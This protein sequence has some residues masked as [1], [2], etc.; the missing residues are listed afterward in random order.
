MKNFI[1][2]AIFS[3]FTF[4][5]FGQFYDDCATAGSNIDNI[6]AGAI[7]YSISG[8]I[9]I[10]FTDDGSYDAT[11]SFAAGTYTTGFY[12]FTVPSNGYYNI[13]FE[14]SGGGTAATGD[15]SVG[16]D[17]TSGT[18]PGAQTDVGDIATG[19]DITS[20]CV[21]LTAGTTYYISMALENGHEGDFTI[22]IDKGE[23]VCEGALQEIFQGDNVLD[24]SCSSNPPSPGTSGTI[25]TTYTVVAGPGGE[26]DHLTVDI[27][28][29]VTGSLNPAFIYQ[30]LLNDCTGD[31]VTANAT[32]LN[33]GDVLYIESGNSS[34]AYGDYTVHIDQGV[35]DVA[36]DDCVD[37]EDR[38]TLTCSATVTGAADANA[39]G[40]EQDCTPN[41]VDGVWYHFVASSAVNTFDFTGSEFRVW[42][43]P[44]CANLTDLGCA[45][46]AALTDVLADPTTIYWVMVYGSGSFTATSDASVPANDL[47]ADAVALVS[48]TTVE[49]STFCA[50]HTWA[51]CALDASSHE[52]YY[53]YTNNTGN[54][55]DIDV[56]VEGSTAT[57]G[58]TA[59]AAVD[60]AI[61]TDACT[62]AAFN[63]QGPECNTL[64][65]SFN[66]ACI[67]P[68][69][70]LILAVGS[71]EGSEGDFKITITE[72]TAGH[73]A[74]DVCAGAG[75]FGEIASSCTKVD[76]PADN[77]GA[78]SDNF[79]DGGCAFTPNTMKSVWY[80][81]STDANAKFVDIETDLTD[82][83]F[84]LYTGP[85]CDNLTYEASSCTS[86]GTLDNLPVLPNTT[87]YILIGSNTTEG[88][89]N[90]GITVKNIPDNNLCAD[91]IDLADGL[92]GTNACADA[93]YDYCAQVTG[94]THEVYY[95]YTNNN[96]ANVDLDVTVTG[97]TNTTGTA[98]T[99][100]DVAI[101]TDACDG[102]LYNAPN[103]TFCATL[104]TQFTIECIEDGETIILVF[105]SEDTQ[106][107][108]FG[109]S[110]TE[111]VS[112]VTNDECSGADEITY[113]ACQWESVS[114]DNTNACFEDFTAAG[115]DYDTEP[116]VWMKFIATAD[117][118]SVE[119]D[120]FTT[121]GTG[122]LGLFEETLDC[123]NQT[124]AA[125]GSACNTGAGPFGPF[126]ITG[127]NT[128]YIAVGSSGG[129]GAIDFDIKVNESPVNDDPCDANFAPKDIADGATL[130]E[131]NTCAGPD[132]TS[133]N[134]DNTS[135]KTL[136]YEHT[137]TQDADLE[138]TV[139]GTTATGPFTI[140]T[141]DGD[142]ACGDES[143]FILDN[144]TDNTLTLLCKLQGEKVV[145][146]I[147]TSET[148]G[149][150][151]EYE[152]SVTE[153]VVARPAND[154]CTDAEEIIYDDIDLCK[155]KGADNNESNI[156]ACSEDNDFGTTCD[157]TNEEV[158]WFEFTTPPATVAG[159]SVSVRFSNYTGTGTLFA[160]MFDDGNDCTALTVA[161][162]G[163]CATGNGPNGLGTVDPNTTYLIGVGSTGDTGGDFDIEIKIT[164]GPPNDDACADMT[165]FDLTG[166]GTL[167]DEQT[168]ACSG[169]GVSF[170]D[171]SG[172]DQTNAVFYTFTI[173]APVY[174]INVQITQ[175]GSEPIQGTVVAGISA[176]NT[177][178]CTGTTYTAP[179]HCEDISTAEFEWKCLDEGT[180][181]LQISTSEDNSGTFEITS[182]MLEKPDNGCNAND[183][184]E[185]AEELTVDAQCEWVD[186][187]KECN[188][189]AC[190]DPYTVGACDLSQ[191]PTVWYKVLIPAGAA[192]I[193]VIVDNPTSGNV[194]MVVAKE[195]DACPL[196]AGWCGSGGT[197]AAP[198]ALDATDEGTYFYIAVTDPTGGN[199][200]GYD[201][202]IKIDV[203]PINDSPCMANDRPP[204]DLG[205]G[206][207]H[208][209]TTCCAVG[210]NDD[211][212]QDQANVSCNSA[213][214]DNAVWYRVA[215]D[216]ASDGV[217]INITGGTIGGSIG[218]EVYVGG[219]DAACD[220]T[221]EF[222]KSK[223]DGL[224]VTDMHIGCLE[225]GDYV[226]IKVASSDNDGDCGTFDITVE[227]IKDCDIADACEDITGAQE[228]DPV[229][230][231]DV[232]VNYVCTQGC[233]DLACPDPGLPGGCAGFNTQPTVWFQINTDAD[234]A[235]LYTSVE[236]SGS[237]TPVWSIF[238]SPNDD[239]T[240][241]QNA[242]GTGS[243]PCSL[244]AAP[245]APPLIT[246]VTEGV[247]YIAVSANDG[248]VIDDPNF[249][250]C[251]ATIKNVVVCLGPDVGCGNDETLVFEVTERENTDAE[252]NGPPYEGPFCPG[253][254]VTVHMQFTYDAT[255]TGDDWI[256]GLIPKFGD[257]WDMTGFDFAGNPPSGTPMGAADYYDENG[258]CPPL[259]ME[260]FSF[261]CTYTDDQGHLRLCNTLCENCPCTGGMIEQDPL[262]SGYFW[263][264]EGTSPDCDANN[265][266]PSRKYGI[267]NPISNIEW[268]IN[269][270][271]KEFATQD[272]CMA[273]DDLLI[274]FMTFSDGGAGC[275]D[276]PIGEC[277]ID[278]PQFSPAWKVNCDIPP[279]V[280]ATPQPQDI[281]SG[282]EAGIDVT[283]EDGSTELIEITYDDNP[284]VDG[285]NDHSFSD[286][287]GTIDDVLTINDP[288]LCDVEVVTYYA[289]VIIPGM[290]CEGKTDTI[291]VNVYPLPRI[292]E[293]DEIFGAC[294]SDLPYDLPIDAECG[295]P[296]TYTFSWMDDLSSKSGEGDNI[297]IDESFGAGLHT[298]SITVT[299]ELGCENTGELKFNVYPDV[300]FKLQGD[301]LCWGEYKEF[302]VDLLGRES[303]DFEF[304]WY[305]DPG[306]GYSGGDETYIIETDEYG[307][308]YSPSENPDDFQL[309][310]ELKE[311][312][313][314]GVVCTHDTCVNVW[315]RK[316]MNLSLN[317][318]NPVYICEGQNCV[319]VEVVFD[320]DN[321]MLFDEVYEIYW[322]GNIT[323]NPEYEFCET[324][325]GNFVQI[326]DVFGC[327]TT[328]DFDILPNAVTDIEIVGDTSICIGDCTTLTV[329]G[330]FDSYAWNTG[331]PA[332]TTKS[333][334]VC[335]MDDLT[336]YEVSAIN[337]SGCVSNGSINVH[338]FTAEVPNIPPTATFC[339]G[340]STTISAPGGYSSYKWY[341]NS[342]GGTPVSTTQDVVID[343]SGNYIIV[344]VSPEGCTAQDTVV[345]SEASE[346]TPYVVGDTSLC[347]EDDK[348]L[349]IALGG[350]FTVYEW[351]FNDASG[352][353]VIPE[354]D[355][356]SIYLAEGTYYLYVSDGNCSG[357]TTF[358]ITRRPKIEPKIMP[359]VD[360]IYICYD[361]DTT[362][363]AP[364]GFVSYK[365]S[366]GPFDRIVSG[367]GEGNYYVTVTD[368]EG[369]QGVDSIYVD[370]YP[371]MYPSLQDSVQ[372]CADDKAILTPG[373]FA[374][375]I[376]SKDNVHLASFD[377]EESIEVTEGG[378]YSVI[379]SNAIGCTA[380]DTIK[381][382]K[383][384]NLTP[385]IVGAKDLC[386][387]DEITLSVSGTY[388]NYKWTNS[389]GK[390]L[391]TDATLKFTMTL[392]K[393][394]ETVLLEVKSNSGCLGSDQ[395]TINRY[396]TPELELDHMRIEVCG[397]GSTNPGVLN[398]NDYFI[399]GNA[400]IGNW[401]DFDNS[402]ATHNA[403][404]SNV[405]FTN[406]VVDTTY[407]FVFRTTTAKAP[408]EDV[409]DTIYVHVKECSCEQWKL[410]PFADVCNDEN[411]AQINL[412]EHV[413]NANGDRIVPV[414]A[415]VWTV[416]PAG[417]GVLSGNKFIAA[418]AESGTYT[419]TYKFNDKGV[420]CTDTASQ[421]ITVQNAVNPGTPQPQHVC[422]GAN[423]VFDLGGLLIG[424]DAGGTWTEVSSN[425]STGGAF[426]A[427]AGTFTTNG[428]NIGEY[429]FEYS[430]KGVDPCPDK[431]V[432]VSVIIDPTP[433]ADAG[434]VSV[435][436]ED[437]PVTLFAKNEADRYEWIKKGSTDVL[438]T[439]REYSTSESGTY[440]LKVF[441]AL[442]CST[443]KDVIVEIKP[444]II[445]EITG[446]TVLQNGATDTLF[447]SVTGRNVDDIR[448]YNWSKDGEAIDT[449]HSNYLVVSDKGVYCAEVEDNAGCTGEACITVTTAI[450][451]E[452]DIP[453]VFSPDTDGK[454]DRF[455]VKDGKNVANIRTFKVWDRW[456]NLVYSDADF[457]FEDRKNH[458][459]DGNYNGKKAMQGV[460]VYLVEFTWSDGKDDFVAGDVTLIR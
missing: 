321:G 361:G 371:R 131:D 340:F 364:D 205:T 187:I 140:A 189:D 382:V 6:A 64:D 75:D 118:T 167:P 63:N 59:A 387:D 171:C 276:D 293:Q 412:G 372:I 458:F 410:S 10:T 190:P 133:C 192:S 451:K 11:L 256:I 348:T 351:R 415:G 25:W 217:N 302:T 303:S 168:N 377:G 124:E 338:V 344:V 437:K 245:P 93:E 228:L 30:V 403:D 21:N 20:D 178:F 92:D 399:K 225:D 145:I 354:T 41:D 231:E 52:V 453:N 160:T 425:P 88:S 298:F 383:T 199:G 306:D 35:L 175:S 279:G 343:K 196:T 15:L 120:N 310:L 432:R 110:M 12:A 164:S 301:T 201:I 271:V 128:Y 4:S 122:F 200:E 333:I 224:P 2:I 405:D 389:S 456:G 96:G 7:P 257:G 320:E 330:D 230:P 1:L 426:D 138:I 281:C 433:I 280:I 191:G 17:P 447:A 216:P 441:S 179:A 53:S 127:G 350:N 244:D 176:V 144:C 284:N 292:P 194:D 24:N 291:E 5:A 268:T 255:Q 240:D 146:M 424:G 36:N 274:N 324:S 326:I 305:W 229:T 314:D 341:Y 99:G 125:A 142:V 300:E 43:G 404:W 159:S 65:Q 379:V 151:G 112:S 325:V 396:H 457:S 263:V 77:T 307:S 283:T 195:A 450:T 353:K 54:T 407:R 315:I 227:S 177:E 259:V 173:T 336:T 250:V 148:A 332:D 264:Q 107:G 204:Y 28:A 49:G 206:G 91:A 152:V 406:V 243:F 136:F 309:C 449:V 278:K 126:A 242:A 363:T 172:D 380:F 422:E 277:L 119:F 322:N 438:G 312:H 359:D 390:V 182:T 62:G 132:F 212:G 239:C 208:S 401:R 83:F 162:G 135:G 156:N 262:P 273:N 385:V 393:D 114:T 50:T 347:F 78:C 68:G 358:T 365:W 69:E 221:A 439:N 113:T 163:G 375:Y 436:F 180:Y 47:C 252:P 100:L 72:N 84:S 409:V 166:G 378:V 367:V 74:N 275:W 86:D 386:E 444:Q 87:Y 368:D 443:E 374:D 384:D 34:P 313:D 76:N 70:T 193:D 154:L 73:P 139:N 233:L 85:D 3:F 260:K 97:N 48:G 150:F 381:V 261:L 26:I 197:L 130:T 153:N 355:K 134:V 370:A 304:N 219:A 266:S 188:E 376:W 308:V 254:E 101:M 454:N 203:P 223:C 295:F 249:Q 357:N 40:G 19:F 319:T 213:S 272:E 408:C 51:Y 329:V 169:A 210:A 420:Y 60:V 137:M 186:F 234:A 337:S 392:G 46:D 414:P 316:P 235:Q 55:V 158:V 222:R 143:N 285:E 58:T 366:N 427:N 352:A 248:D 297:V 362:L 115:C 369:C 296:G 323:N 117:A 82:A 105:G 445:V 448:L 29:V 104:G 170:P 459:W 32:C 183:K 299:D 346:L 116:V 226:F 147:G 215:Y 421:T 67:D 430:L 209:G 81:F 161:A 289:Q 79:N 57:N 327:D 442:G 360:T 155:W 31:D 165:N 42:T 108:D 395:V 22:T 388:D 141:Y 185:D 452:I 317:P 214:D 418:G 288:D 71:E 286:G 33:E 157:Y 334:T 328:I 287:Y 417:A 23:D 398:F 402:N 440:V 103:N 181:Q 416:T 8:S 349:M 174:G 111:N 335:P 237:W 56:L 253:E 44:D 61:L 37:A 129:E 45:G 342:T 102:T 429:V 123:D 446:E 95:K 90:I 149:E 39:C 258:D 435:C 218:V 109:I 202:H 14:A 294:M 198:I 13:H 455:F 434:D 251:A 394:V 411:S 356:D 247:Y 27:T 211:P 282:S 241:L 220:G 184:C 270:K 246:G 391:G 267:G 345:A 94:T 16:W 339:T 290:I 311:E 331:D 89:F 419:I 413:V 423:E 121:A 400:T 373:K 431:S 318:G 80:S 238:Y 66:I 38:G 397:Q 106:E 269:L 265:C 428:Q 236:T 207:S 18:C 98:A 9:P 232:E 460:Y